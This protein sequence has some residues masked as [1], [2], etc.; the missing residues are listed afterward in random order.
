MVFDLGY[1]DQMRA[2]AAAT[3]GQP[4]PIDAAFGRRVLDVVCGAYASA[5]SGGPVALPFAGSRDRTPLD[6]WRG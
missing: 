1:V 2:L 4:S 5:G 3:A 6:L